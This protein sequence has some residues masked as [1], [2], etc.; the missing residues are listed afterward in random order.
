MSDLA[1]EDKIRKIRQDLY[2]FNIG[3]QESLEKYLEEHR[4]LQFNELDSPQKSHSSGLRN[5]LQSSHSAENL[6]SSE[7]FDSTP[8]FFKYHP[9]STANYL[10]NKKKKELEN[11]SEQDLIQYNQALV[12]SL[13]E[14]KA[15]YIKMLA[16]KDERVMYLEQKVKRLDSELSFYKQG[17]SNVEELKSSTRDL[18]CKADE[19]D[20]ERMSLAKENTQ[21]HQ[22]LLSFEREFSQIA[23]ESFQIKEANKKLHN[24]NSKLSRH[25]DEISKEK[26]LLY[27]TLNSN[28]PTSRARTISA[29][30]SPKVSYPKKISLVEFPRKKIFSDDERTER[31]G[32]S[33]SLN[34]KTR[35]VPRPNIK[36]GLTHSISC[37]IVKELM[38]LYT[39]DSPSLLVPLIKA[40]I[41]EVKT[42]LPYKEFL[43]TV[44]KLIVANS[45]PNSFKGLPGVKLSLKWIKRLVKEY[46]ELQKKS[47][48]FV[49]KRILDVL[50]AGLNSKNYEDIPR[51]ISKLLVENERLLQVLSKIKRSY[52]LASNV[53]IE[54]LEREIDSRLIT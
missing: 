33:P 38:K 24:E 40:N 37:K 30:S 11:N 45:P 51:A 17:R 42:H 44:Q 8:Q 50:V 18:K 3:N 35:K 34:L 2:N 32:R 27:K 22:K 21:L 43:N 12:S 4:E 14:N 9:E 31:K 25:I 48:E 52:R 23:N 20:H 15:K 46:L 54:D 26:D 41:Q 19:L 7:E 16:E 1:I 5:G 10:E 53:S 36:P 29:S 28:R 47:S 13:S 6:K 49:E 39:I